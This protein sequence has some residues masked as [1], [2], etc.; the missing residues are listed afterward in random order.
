M[1]TF[2]FLSILFL[3]CIYNFYSQDKIILKPYN[4]YLTRGP[5]LSYENLLSLKLSEILLFKDAFQYSDKLEKG[6]YTVTSDN[7]YFY[8]NFSLDRSN[9]ISDTKSIPKDVIKFKKKVVLVEGNKINVLDM[10]EPDKFIDFNKAVCTFNELLVPMTNNN[11]PK[12]GYYWF[13]RLLIDEEICHY[14]SENNYGKILNKTVTT[15]HVIT[16]E[17]Q[18]CEMFATATDKDIITYTCNGI[19]TIRD[20]T[21]DKIWN[22]VTWGDENISNP[23]A[24]VYGTSGNG[25]DQF[26]SPTGIVVGA[27]YV[28]G[29]GNNYP[30]YV[31]DQGNNRIVKFVYFTDCIFGISTIQ[32]G[33]FSII[34]SVTS[35]FDIEFHP[36]ANL[37]NQNDDVLWYSQNIGSRKGLQAINAVN[38]NLLCDVTAFFYKGNEY[39]LNPLRIS[40]YRSP[41][42]ETNILACIDNLLH[43]VIFFK[44]NS[45]GTLP[46]NPP[47]STSAWCFNTWDYLTCVKIISSNPYFLDAIVSYNDGQNHGCI[48]LF[49]IN[50]LDG[51][52]FTEYLGSSFMG[53]NSDLAFNCLN[54]LS[55]R[56]GFINILTLE[57]W[58]NQYGIRKY[59]PGLN[60]ISQSNTMYC[61]DR[62]GIKLSYRITNPASIGFTNP[63]YST[64]GGINWIPTSYT[65][66]NGVYYTG[67]TR[68]LQSGNNVVIIGMNLPNTDSNDGGLIKFEVYMAPQDFAF[69]SNDPEAIHIIYDGVGY[70]PCNPGGT[71]CPYLYVLDRDSLRLENNILHKSEIS[72]FLNTDI[73]DNYKINNNI[74][75]T[76]SDSTCTMQIKE[77][78]NDYSY[79]DRFQLKAIDHPLGTMLDVTENNDLVLYFP[80]SVISPDSA[81]LNDSDVTYQLQ[82]DSLLN[83]SVAGDSTDA[84]YSMNYNKSYRKL[85]NPFKTSLNLL[86][87]NLGNKII[88]N[89][90][91]KAG[92]KVTEIEDSIAVIS[93][94]QRDILYIIPNKSVY[95]AELWGFNNGD[96]YSSGQKFFARR[97]NR[98]VIVVP[99]SKYEY[100]DSLYVKWYRDFNITYM[101]TVPI[102]YGGYI[103]ND[104]PLNSAQ[105]SVQGDVTYLLLEKDNQYAEMD[106]TANITL[107]FKNTPEPIP[108]GWV[109]DYIF[110][111]DGRYI[112]RSGDKK[113]TM[114]NNNSNIPKVF[115]LHQNYPN[116]FNPITK[117]KY[118]IPKNVNVSIK[119]YDILG[120]EVKLLIN[121]FKTAGYYEVDFDGTNYA[122]GVYF[123][124]IEA[125]S[126]VK[127]N[128]MVLVK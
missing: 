121:E 58:D 56:S 41:D 19:T 125:G 99:V 102:Y 49:K 74:D 117:I 70:G 21:V 23:C 110:V 119:L 104:L 33:S 107:H 43:A 55:C 78:N 115:S 116:P 44:L 118:D 97:E 105:H 35:P 63:Y 5:N 113:L 30:I 66:I 82:Y 47:T 12:I 77:L 36:G 76:K 20:F 100:I 86:K 114:V 106:N 73:T 37:Y 90:N 7:D 62:G 83:N 94:P 127:C 34:K 46:Q 31:A 126:F 22:R 85:I 48:N 13:N 28:S 91:K 98:S 120:R 42:G 9:S 51:N 89:N 45:D 4:K 84:I 32:Q 108:D 93:D 60:M 124:R 27:P 72:V 40:V 71:G 59:K 79:F 54:N 17:Y 96:N 16:P 57:N 25:I 61:T 122:S 11:I 53:Y 65:Y 26:N 50:I 64:N 18:A 39:Q 123:Y 29:G 109:R 8:V 92:V 15:Q 6:A 80:P 81:L 2:K 1:K 69:P 111:T 3:I 128:K 103:E 14:N 75:F 95:T 88:S 24:Q 38:G 67:T 112:N 68:Y 101:C 52:P 87:K 10:V